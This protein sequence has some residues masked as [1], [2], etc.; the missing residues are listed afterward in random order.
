MG[1]FEPDDPVKE[2]VTI[3]LNER[4]QQDG[5]FGLEE[6]TEIEEKIIQFSKH[7]ETILVLGA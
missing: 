1:Y 6:L 2:N 5:S 4:K 3:N 7:Y